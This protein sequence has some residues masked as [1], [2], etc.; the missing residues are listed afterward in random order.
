MLSD[1][2][3]KAVAGKVNP[4]LDF[5]L[6]MEKKN[7]EM[8]SGKCNAAK[9]RQSGVSMRSVVTLIERCTSGY[10][11]GLVAPRTY[12]RSHGVDF[13]E[14]YKSRLRQRFESR[15]LMLGK[16]ELLLLWY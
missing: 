11:V 9:T 7:Q 5:M 12:V 3:G 8:S 13:M 10:G 16:N 15:R 1:H 2:G 14:K 4:L 6:F